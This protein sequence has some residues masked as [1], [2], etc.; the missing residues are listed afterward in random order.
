MSKYKWGWYRDL[1][2][3]LL[4]KELTVR[5]KGSFLGFFWSILNPLANAFLFYLV[6]NIY[7]RFNTPHYI[8]VLLSAMFP[9]QWFA[10]CVSEGPFVFLANPS[11]VKKVA[12]PRQFIPLVMIL[13]HMVHFFLALPIYTLFLLHEGMYPGLIWLWGI[14]LL[15][16]LS[17]STIYGLTLAVGSVNLFFKDVGNLV[18]IIIQAAFFATPIMYLL[19]IVPENLHWCFKVNPIAPLFIC[20]RS[21][22]LDNSLNM[23]FFWYATMYA[24]FFLSMGVLAYRCLCQRFA[25]AM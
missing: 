9:W 5:Y 20:W 24:G 21:L 8:V 2:L 16:M 3:V 7:M 18:G 12:F 25:E 19:S 22:L 13:Q 15:A 11:L 17:L 10:N 14:P 23:D 1:T 6:F 4:H